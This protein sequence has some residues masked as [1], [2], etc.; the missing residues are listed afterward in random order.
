MWVFDH[1]FQFL[2]FFSHNN[3]IARRAL[4]S[5]QVFG[6]SPSGD[7]NEKFWDILVFTQQVSRLM[8]SEIRR[9]ASN[10]STETASCA[11]VKF[12]EIEN[13]EESSNGWMLLSALNLLAAG[14]TSLI[15]VNLKFIWLSTADTMF[16]SCDCFLICRPWPL[17]QSRQLWW[18]VCICSSIYPRWM[19]KM[20]ILQMP[21]VNSLL[22]NVGY[23]YKKYL[24]RW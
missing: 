10:Q 2:Y 18:N 7:M 23:Y 8:V 14:D 15:Q 11:I 19:R 1:V 22:E 12:L 17:L 3:A 6:S 4:C 20:L 21:I 9:R 5:F 16:L 13:S 24:F